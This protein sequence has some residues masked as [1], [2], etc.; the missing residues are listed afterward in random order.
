MAAQPHILRLWVT[1]YRFRDKPVWLAQISMPLGGRFAGLLAGDND[2]LTDPNVDDARLD[3]LQ[4]LM[5]SQHV[6][7]VGFVSG[8]GNV[9]AGQPRE[10]F[11][12]ST[13][14]T[15]GLRAV[16]LLNSRNRSI[17][18]IQIIDWER[19]ADFRNREPDAPA[20]AGSPTE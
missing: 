5:Y 6:G 10:T 20:A 19:P 15:D 18:N 3:L 14:H 4:D 11:T 12:G 1:P 13:Y 8:A 9:P 7:A 2:L 17:G 16:L